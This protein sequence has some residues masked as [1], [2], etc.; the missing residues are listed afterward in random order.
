MIEILVRLLLRSRETSLMITRTALPTVVVIAMTE[1]TAATV[2]T[3]SSA[4]TARMRLI[5]WRMKYLLAAT[6]SLRA[7][8]TTTLSM[9]MPVMTA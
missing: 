6:M 3:S 9:A 5:C 4:M 7:V 1:F 2:L 8:P